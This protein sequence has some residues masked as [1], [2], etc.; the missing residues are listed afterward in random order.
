MKIYLDDERQMPSGFDI[1]VKSAD[2]AIALLVAGGVS[3]I[4]LDHDLGDEGNGTG[5]DVA[6][7]IERSAYEG[8]LKSLEVTIHSANPIG[9]ARMEQAIA[10]ARQYWN[11]QN[12]G[13]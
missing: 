3:A 9:R 12:T 8:T 11:M 6:C 13:G 5:Y 1:H 10:K 7:F 2:E 4:S